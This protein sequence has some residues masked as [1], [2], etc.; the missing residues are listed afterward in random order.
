MT[1]FQL[2]AEVWVDPVAGRVY[3]HGWQSWTPTW[4]YRLDERP[5]RVLDPA[6]HVVNYRLRPPSAGFHADGLLAVDPGTGAPVRVWA[7]ADP[8]TAVASIRA[9]VHNGW[10]LVG[11]DGPVTETAWSGRLPAA[12][13]GW[14]DS[15]AAVLHPGPVRPA[16]TIWCSWYQYFRDVTAADVL[17]NLSTM[18]SLALPVD[19]VQVDDGYQAEIGDWLTWTERFGSV[20]GLAARIRA[21]GRRAGIWVAPFLVGA[22]SMVARRHPE[23]LVGDPAAADRTPAPAGWHW[24]QQLYALDVT[25]PAAADWLVGVF[26]TFAGLGIDFF[27]VDFGYAGA[28]PGRRRVDLPAVVAYRHGLELIR[29]G[30]GPDAYLLGCGTPIL[31]SIGLVD[32]MRVGPDITVEYEPAG[33]DMSAPAQRSAVRNGVARAFQH[34]RWW[35]NDPD[36]IL[37]RPQ[38]QRRADWAAHIERYGGLRGCGDGLSELDGWGVSTT[39]RLLATVPPPT[40]F[41]VPPPPRG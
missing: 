38:V 39:R 7:A 19:V 35:V 10:L 2:V 26:A 11:A 3:E 12:L 32:A 34:G 23:W 9:E 14:A 29:A 20:A 37:A 13:A 5:A 25:H 36:C 6:W 8:T 24:G 31:P 41:P 18:D 17:A 27:K 33:G 16:P 28:L 30:I 15:C 40:P 4:T 22:R 1:G 21:A